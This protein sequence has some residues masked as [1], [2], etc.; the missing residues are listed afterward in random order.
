MKKLI[1]LLDFFFLSAG[2]EYLVMT[3]AALMTLGVT[4]FKFA[5]YYG[6]AVGLGIVAGSLW[7]GFILLIIGEKRDRSSKESDHSRGE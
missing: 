6:V 7:L 1:G 5:P 2:F 4:S 3:G